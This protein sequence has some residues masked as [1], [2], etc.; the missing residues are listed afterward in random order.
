MKKFLKDLFIFLAIFSII[1]F[2]GL[3]ITKFL[4]YHE[5]RKKTFSSP[6]EKGIV[7]TFHGIYGE[8]KDL[9]KIAE[10]LKENGYSGVNIQYPTTEGTIEEITEKYISGEIKYYSD[11]VKKE[12]ERRKKENLPEI[13]IHFVVHS[14]G[15]VILRHYLKNNSIEHMGKVVFLSPP[16]HGSHLADLRIV[17]LMN[18]TLGAAASQFKTFP[19]SFVNHLGRPH[20]NCYV[21]MGNK[22]NNFFYSWII[23]GTD[24]GM[25]PFNT[26]KLSGCKYRTIENTTHTS[27]LSDKRTLKEIVDYLEK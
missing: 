17:S 10:T 2:I 11:Y 19:D 27:I 1:V 8:D 12:N 22:S 16:S 13:K 24:D 7:I 14:L 9:E 20:Y 18:G 25:V 6:Y 3:K 26:A 21:L 4:L 15:S 23:P 5:Y